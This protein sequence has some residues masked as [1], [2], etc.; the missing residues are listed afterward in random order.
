MILQG[1]ARLVLWPWTQGGPGVQK[2]PAEGWPWACL[3]Q[4]HVASPGKLVGRSQPRQDKW[5][6]LG[7]G[8]LSPGW[9]RR[10]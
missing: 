9:A 7:L 6:L 1:G 3:D 8:G 2:L 5:K 4:G 10:P